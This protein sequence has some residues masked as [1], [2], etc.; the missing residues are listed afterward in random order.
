MS[1]STQALASP[2]CDAI[3]QR[4]YYYYYYYYYCY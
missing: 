3:W 4:Y 2:R 1:I